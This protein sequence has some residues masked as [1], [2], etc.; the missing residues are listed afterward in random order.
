ME[1]KHKHRFDLINQMILEMAS[2]NFHFRLGR[3]KRNDTLEGLLVTLNM[4]AEEIQAVMY[5]QGFAVDNN[6]Q[7]SLVQMGF[8]VNRHGFVRMVNQQSCTILSMDYC[9]IINRPFVELLDSSS[10]G[11][12][13]QWLHQVE[14]KDHLDFDLELVF[15]DKKGLL[16]PKNC[17][18]SYLRDK[19]FSPE[20]ILITTVHQKSQHD[21]FEA[22]IKQKIVTHIYKSEPVKPIVDNSKKRK[23]LTFEDIK[24]IKRGHDYILN[25]IGDKFPSLKEFALQLGTNEFKLKYGFK[26]LYGISV[27]RYL[28]QERLRQAKM[29]VQFSDMPLKVVASRTGFKSFPHFSKTFKQHFGYNPSEMRRMANEQPKLKGNRS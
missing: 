13:I 8:L 11:E 1:G 15:K 26:E 4:L 3:T 6:V 27:Y 2:G 19:N 14:M 12:W 18:V 24:I 22:E 28:I 21:E 9:D 25:N 7:R 29:F 10:K 5:H 23:K 17:I 20:E 16:I